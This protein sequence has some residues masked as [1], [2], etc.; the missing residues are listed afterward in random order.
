[1]RATVSPTGRMCMSGAM[2]ASMNGP[3]P[4]RVVRDICWI[5]ARP[6]GRSRSWILSVYVG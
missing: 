1:M 3:P 5:S 2:K 6:P 4:G